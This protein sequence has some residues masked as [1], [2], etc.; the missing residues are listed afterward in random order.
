MRRSDLW[1]VYLLLDDRSRLYIGMSSDVSH[2]LRTHRQN[3]GAKLLRNAATISLVGAVPIGTRAQAACFERKAKHWPAEHKLTLFSR[4]RNTWE[5]F[6]RQEDRHSALQ[7]L[8]VAIRQHRDAE[9]LLDEARLKIDRSVQKAAPDLVTCLDEAG[10]AS[11]EWRDWLCHDNRELGSSPGDALVA[12]R[13]ANVL[14]WIFRTR[15][16]IPLDSVSGERR[17]ARLTSL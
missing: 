15:Y 7:E 17:Q 2:R 3:H 1:W 4:Y 12:G 10:Y 13:G 6:L 9:R 14:A 8:D 5:D 11:L 16:G